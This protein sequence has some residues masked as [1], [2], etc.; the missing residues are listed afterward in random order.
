MNKLILG[1]TLSSLISSFTFAAE[2]PNCKT[3]GSKLPSIKNQ[4]AKFNYDLKTK[5]ELGNYLLT[6]LKLQKQ[7]YTLMESGSV[8]SR[9]EKELNQDELKLLGVLASLEKK[10]ALEPSL[11]KA[12]QHPILKSKTEKLEPGLLEAMLP[13]L[14]SAIQAQLNLLGLTG[15]T[16]NIPSWQKISKGFEASLLDYK[17]NKELN[18]AEGNSHWESSFLAL[19]QS[20]GIKMMSGYN[21][22][23][24]V[25]GPVSFK[26]KRDII[27]SAKKT[28]HIY[29]WS[30]YDDL[31]GREFRDLLKFKAAQGVKVRII[32]DGNV[33]KK[34]KHREVIQELKNTENIELVEFQDPNNPLFG[35]HRKA[36]VVDG[37]KLNAG[38]TNFGVYYSHAG[39]TKQKWRD[40]D[41][42]VEGNV[43]I[44]ADLDFLS[45]FNRLTKQNIKS[46]ASYALKNNEHRDYSF[47]SQG[48]GE[49]KVWELTLA[50]IESAQTKI[51]I[52][53]AY[54]IFT[55][56][57][58]NALERAIKDRGVEVIIHTNSSKSVDE[59]IVSVPI[60][61]TAKEL[62]Q[63]GAQVFLKKGDTLH[64]KFMAVDSEV[65]L[66][67]S[68]N[69]HPRS[70]RL[71]AEDAI[72]SR[73]PVD[74]E[75][76]KNMFREDI[77][78]V[79]SVEIKSA[80]EIQVP[81]NA[82]AILGLRVFFDQL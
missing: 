77:S 12:L 11:I 57:I 9:A 69:L 78:E 20:L 79:N 36:I 63:M 7:A 39:K 25:D 53:N 67:T 68:L 10:S 17:Q 28:I 38:G 40:T 24:L 48:A 37:R 43:A 66:I 15:P 26:N 64:T 51:E 52:S 8:P 59:P 46:V 6:A 61:K 45:S 3:I 65:I 23:L 73:N 31:T 56:S 4:I 29:S 35:M 34:P 30:I 41:I 80:E 74:I 72:I 14:I 82:G 13:Q 50:L 58:R 44:Q 16:K 54:V 5:V 19:E 32:V 18:E 22:K 75:A 70:I 42:Y 62:K 60:L 47:V 81:Y 1:F 21:S 27:L 71:E 49:S 33:S 2:T 76:A 55:P